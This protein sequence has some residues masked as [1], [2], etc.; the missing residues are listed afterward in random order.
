[1]SGDQYIV[2][3]V[4]LT[5]GPVD[6][7]TNSVFISLVLECIHNWNKYTQQLAESPL[8]YSDLWSEGYYGGKD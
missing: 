8:L 7:Q 5:V 3:Y 6:L 4:H 2:V 1:M